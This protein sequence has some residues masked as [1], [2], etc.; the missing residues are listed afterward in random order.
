MRPKTRSVMRALKVCRV[1]VALALT[2]VL[3]DHAVRAVPQATLSV[4]MSNPAC[5]QARANSGTCYIIIRSVSASASDSS[6]TGLDITINDK[7]RAR[8]QPF[9]ETTANLVASMLGQ[10]LMVTCGRPNA[11]GDPNL[12]LRYDVAYKGYLF[13]SSTPAAFGSA[14]VYCPAYESQVYSPLIRR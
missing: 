2:V 10:G 3:S 12:G 7:V 8:M 11:S 13:G 1:L 6:F 5:V 9:F 4:T 14:A